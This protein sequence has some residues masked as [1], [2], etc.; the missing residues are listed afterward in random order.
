[1][2]IPF[3]DLKRLKELFDLEG[4][5]MPTELIKD[6]AIEVLEELPETKL[7]DVYDYLIKL[8]YSK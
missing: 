1:M 7:R 4:K 2:V 5:L 8:K 6:C 3:N